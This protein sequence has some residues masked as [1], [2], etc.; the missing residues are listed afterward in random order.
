MVSAGA[1]WRLLCELASSSLVDL[2]N[3]FAKDHHHVLFELNHIIWLI[4]SV[5]NS[6]AVAIGLTASN[7]LLL[8]VFLE[9]LQEGVLVKNLGK[10]AHFT[11]VV[12]KCYTEPG[13]VTVTFKTLPV[14]DL[15]IVQAGVLSAHV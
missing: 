12:V 8:E 1:E 14:L 6:T 3:F 5:E 2:F 7:C 13:N 10:V 11:L 9:V 4:G 15:F